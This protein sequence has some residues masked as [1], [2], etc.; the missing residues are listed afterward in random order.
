MRL[1]K[2]ISVV[3]AALMLGAVLAGCNKEEDTTWKDFCF[4]A[5]PVITGG[6]DFQNI[7]DMAYNGDKFIIAAYNIEY[8]EDRSDYDSYVYHNFLAVVDE[9]DGIVKKAEITSDYSHFYAASDGTFYAVEV[10]YQ[11][12]VDINGR[13][14]VDSDYNVVTIDEDLNITRVLDLSVIIPNSNFAYIADFKA[15]TDGNV[16][17]LLSKN[18]YGFNTSTGNLFFTEDSASGRVK[19]FALSPAGDMNLIMN[20]VTTTT[21]GSKFTDVIAKIDTK[22]GS[23][24]DSMPFSSEEQTITGGK[25]YGYYTYNSSNIYGINTKTSEKNV[26]ADLLTSGCASLEFRKILYV[27]ENKFA[28]L[29]SDRS[30][31]IT[32]IYMLEKIDP[33]D[34]PD[35]EI[36]TVTAVYSNLYVD[37][38]IK[39]F[40]QR[41]KEYQAELKTYE[42]EG[43]SYSDQLTAFNADFAAGN[44]PD[45]LIVDQRMDYFSYVN[46]NLFVDLYPLIDEDPDIKRED[47]VQP[48]MKAH[49][50]NGKLFS[51]TPNY[52]I[53]TFIGKTEVFGEKK[54]QSL[55]ELQAAA[56]AYPDANLFY[57]N[58]SA[59][60]M[61]ANVVDF[62]LTDYVDYSTRQCYFDTPEFIAL[63]ESA[64]GFPVEVNDSTYDHEAYLNSLANDRTLIFDTGFSDFRDI[65]DL[66]K[67]YFD[68]PVTLLGYPR[69]NGSAGAWVG[70]IDEVAILS[71]AKNPDGAW[72]FVK[73]FMQYKGPEDT[74]TMTYSPK[75]FSIWQKHMDDFAA[76]ALYDPYYTDYTTGEKVYK[77]NAAFVNGQVLFLPNNTPEDNAKVLELINGVTRV[78]RN[79][80]PL[81]RI[82]REEASYFFNGQKTAEETAALIQDRATTYLEETK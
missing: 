51:I 52:N 78:N 24:G 54:G 37:Y 79:D 47:L 3:L 9:K 28:V 68:D 45:V 35:K 5:V 55:D 70:T 33:K 14:Y 7:S 31:H 60:D 49:E 39:E 43:A 1:S 4:D 80:K 82:I 32:G 71:N 57:M 67:A 59:S 30:T 2:F 66:E 64:K 13:T 21:E 42:S 65:V 22:D 72:E 69:R 8:P 58:K 62:S 6:T 29:A 23:L 75:Y 19:G 81:M 61:V 77:K 74:Q 63:L 56:A 16:Y 50:T 27:S 46:K 53:Y 76:D 12:F 36:I 15:D 44:N 34:V 38:Y 18:A 10:K 73:G 25:K 11:E 17:I 26:I 48:V 40:N 20:E 41:N